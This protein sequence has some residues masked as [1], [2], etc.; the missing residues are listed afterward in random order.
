M[1]KK[2]GWRIPNKKVAYFTILQISDPNT[3]RKNNSTIVKWLKI[4]STEDQYPKLHKVLFV[5][6]LLIVLPVYNAPPNTLISNYIRVSYRFKSM[7]NLKWEKELGMKTENKKWRVRHWNAS[8]TN[9][10]VVESWLFPRK[11]CSWRRCGWHPR[12]K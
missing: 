12:S 2:E 5:F 4:S 9:L 8:A 3:S 6:V 10:E 7:H 11:T 1:L